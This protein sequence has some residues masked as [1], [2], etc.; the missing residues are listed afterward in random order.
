MNL[1]FTPPDDQQKGLIAS[2]LKQSYAAL[3]ESDSEHFRPEVPKWEQYDREVFEYPDTVGECL[4]L[5]WLGDEMIGF[6]S[7]DPRQAPKSGI[8]GHNCVLPEFRGQG[9]GKQQIQEIIRQFRSRGVQRVILST[10]DHPFFIP[11]QRMYTAC[12]F[13]EIKH[14]PWEGN[15]ARQMIQYEMML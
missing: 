9:F 15:P 14:F 11:A 7:F 12:G 10:N 6:G 4:F 2:M 13:K 1:R 3:L 5:S 8:I